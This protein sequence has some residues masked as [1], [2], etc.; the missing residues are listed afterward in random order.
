VLVLEEVVVVVPFAVVGM[1]KV[2]D[3]TP[4]ICRT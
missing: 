3:L 4:M 1:S 2:R